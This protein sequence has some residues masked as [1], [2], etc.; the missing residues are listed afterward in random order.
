MSGRS[1]RPC[2]PRAGLDRRVVGHH[3]HRPPLDATDARHDAVGEQVGGLVVGQ[4]A[5]LDERVGV[6]QQRQPVADEELVLGLELVAARG[7]VP[8]RACSV[9]HAPLGR[10]RERWSSRC[11]VV[12]RRVVARGHV[13]RCAMARMATS[14]L[15]DSTCV[16]AGRLEQVLAQH[17]AA[18]LG[19]RRNALAMRSSPKIWSP[20]RTSAS[21][22][23]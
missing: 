2:A 13:G 7:E 10:V 16:V 8:A 17:P 22:S 9:S 20:L 6:E 21:P 14:S 15:N 19:S 12:A 18:T 23:V 5:V 11:G 3:A 4:Q 1:S